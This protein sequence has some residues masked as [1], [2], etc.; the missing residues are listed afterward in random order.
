LQSWNLTAGSI[1]GVTPSRS[2]IY[3]GSYPG[4][5]AIYLYADINAP[6]MHDFIYSILF[7]LGGSRGDTA[8]IFADPAQQ[9]DPG[10]YVATLSELKF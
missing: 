3:A 1:D 2:I 5:R 7:S 4:S 6:G 10:K 9:R 8:V